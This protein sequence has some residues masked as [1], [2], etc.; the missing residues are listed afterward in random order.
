MSTRIEHRERVGSVDF[1]TVQ[2]HLD[3]RV[4]AER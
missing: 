1:P 4:N 3:R 2:V